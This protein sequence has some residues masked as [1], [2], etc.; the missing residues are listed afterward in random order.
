MGNKVEEEEDI[1]AI[2]LEAKIIAKRIKELFNERDGKTFKVFDK[3]TNEYR[4]IKYKDI[5]ILT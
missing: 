3:D 5:V 2:A 4:N 1:D